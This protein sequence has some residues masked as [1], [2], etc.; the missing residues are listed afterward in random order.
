MR[1][2]HRWP[3]NSSNKWPVTRKIFPF[4]YVIKYATTITEAHS[5][6]RAD[7]EPSNWQHLMSVRPKQATRCIIILSQSN[8]ALWR[9]YSM[10]YVII[11]SVSSLLL[12]GHQAVMCTNCKIFSLEKRYWIYFLIF[13]ILISKTVSRYIMRPI[14][15]YNGRAVASFTNIE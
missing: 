6:G 4:D 8:G 13:N 11:Y 5:Y 2:I 7:D 1:G 15:P 12:V 10:N 14:L 9:I 3:V